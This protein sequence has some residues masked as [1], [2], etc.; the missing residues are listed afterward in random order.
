MSIFHRAVQLRFYGR[1]IH[2]VFWLITLSILVFST[3]SCDQVK[4]RSKMHPNG[5]IAEKYEYT[6]A[7]NGAELIEGSREIY[8]EDGKLLERTN[9]N[10]GIMMGLSTKYFPNGQKKSEANYV[11]G[12]KE[13]PEKFWFENGKVELEVEWKAGKKEGVEMAYHPDG[14]PR[15]EVQYRDGKRQGLQKSWNRSGHLF[16]EKDWKDNGI[17]AVRTFVDST[18]IQ[19][20]RLEYGPGKPAKE[21]GYYM[22]D[23]QVEIKHGILRE[24]HKN[25]ELEREVPYISGL[26][27][28]VE[29]IYRDDGTMLSSIDWEQGQKNG[30]EVIWWEN[31]KSKKQQSHYIN[32]KID[33]TSQSWYVSGELREEIIYINGLR[34]GPTISWYQGGKKA[35]EE[36]YK[37]DKLNGVAL[38][39]YADGKKSFEC[40]HVAGARDGLCMSYY[41]NGKL[42]SRVKYRDGVRLA[43]T[44]ENFAENGELQARDEA[45]KMVEQIQ[46]DKDLVRSALACQQA[47]DVQKNAKTASE[48]AKYQEK[49]DKLL[50]WSQSRDSEKKTC[51]SFASV[52]QEYSKRY[53]AKALMEAAQKGD[54][55]HLLNLKE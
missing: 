48:K 14:N 45:R 50:K 28:G 44:A 16:Q 18:K 42:Q 29:K 19:V 25:G 15:S 34:E 51:E 12:K 52:H 54:F 8:S 10:D 43:E 20:Y 1:P 35:S 46:D 38:R 22:E 47:M 33:G 36:P 37:D 31:G 39:Y 17:V 30:T 23:G 3:V 6:V 2:Q 21:Y 7:E 26:K 41:P 24:W 40:S 9:Y 11:G 4:K 32:G 49:Q 55:A 53:G 5:K 27:W 13:G